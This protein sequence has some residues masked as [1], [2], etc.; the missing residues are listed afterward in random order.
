MNL[1]MGYTYLIPILFASYLIGSI[2]FS[3]ILV[4]VFYKRDLRSVGSG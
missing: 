4:K 2:P 3:W 1:L